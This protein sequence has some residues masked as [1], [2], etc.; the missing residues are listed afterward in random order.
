MFTCRDVAGFF[1]L[2]E[3]R[4]PAA[5]VKEN[6]E[7]SKSGSTGVLTKTQGERQHRDEPW[8]SR[9]YRANTEPWHWRTTTPSSASELSRVPAVR[10]VRT[11]AM[12]ARQHRILSFHAACTRVPDTTLCG[13]VENH[14]KG[15]SSTRDP[16]VLVVRGWCVLGVN[17]MCH[18]LG[19][20]TR[21][22]VCSRT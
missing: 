21:C 4:G 6:G 13:A 1:P 8:D 20:G 5:P 16:L 10:Y 14:T 2:L 3:V 22:T 17:T 9:Q 12:R 18:T 7:A 11:L 19:E 15:E